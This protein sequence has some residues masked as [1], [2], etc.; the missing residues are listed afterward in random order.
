MGNVLCLKCVMTVTCYDI[1]YNYWYFMNAKDMSHPLSIIHY[2]L[3][4]ITLWQLSSMSA[5]QSSMPTLLVL[6]PS[7]QYNIFYSISI[8][9]N[10][11]YCNQ[12]NTIIIY[13]S[14]KQLLL[15]EGHNKLW[16]IE[17]KSYNH[18]K[19]GSTLFFFW[20]V[21]QVSLIP[22]LLSD[23]HFPQSSIKWPFSLFPFPLFS[24]F[25]FQVNTSLLH[26]LQS[27]G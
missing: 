9:I 2:E 16:Q 25:R 3:A 27:W 18:T 20:Y 11:N 22:R 1:I 5:R 10:N 14:I 26:F 23:W 15:L 17:S 6:V 21:R 12:C 19:I 13:N 24:L 7:V 8:V 4:V